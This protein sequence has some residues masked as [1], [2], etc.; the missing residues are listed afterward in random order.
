M[1][2]T[3][4]VLGCALVCSCRQ[5][6]DSSAQRSDARQVSVVVSIP[7]L[8]GLVRELLQGVPSQVTCLVPVGVSEHGYEI[9]PDR[10]ASAAKADV[11]VYVGRGLEPQVQKLADRSDPA[12][13]Q[14]VEFAKCLGE[15]RDVAG[16]A[17][18]H[19]QAGHGTDED[20]HDHHDHA[21]DP[22]LWLDPYNI[23]LFMPEVRHAIERGLDRAKLLT[24]EC[25]QLLAKN[26]R[27]LLERVDSV[28]A[29]YQQ[30][31]G[32][33]RDGTRRVVVAHD[34]YQALARR[35]GVEFVPIAGLNA[36]EPTMNDIQRAVE[37]VKQMQAKVVFVEPQLSRSAAERV[38]QATGARV[39]VLDPVG[40]E[41]WFATMDKNLSALTDGLGNNPRITGN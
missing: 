38:A 41:D 16:K 27:L 37:A 31:L 6:P 36:A 21:H 35:Y 11:L 5:R 28:D 14:V 4:C 33:V 18:E 39:L 22:H 29:R 20:E 30:A 40:G 2:W 17:T 3:A 15:G 7:P 32:A 23:K 12:R 25:A 13:Q 24:P 19:E 9:P 8:V 34:A 26:E 10:L 1:F